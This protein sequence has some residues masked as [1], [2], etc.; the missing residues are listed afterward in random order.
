MGRLFWIV[1][2]DEI[3]KELSLE[4]LLEVKLERDRFDGSE[5]ET[6]EFAQLW[7]AITYVKDT[8][9]TTNIDIISIRLTL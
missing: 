5:S 6:A 2:H 3:L 9:T 7:E 8:I 4:S 1:T